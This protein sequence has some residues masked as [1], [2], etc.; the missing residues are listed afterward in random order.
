MPLVLDVSPT[1]VT[2]IIVSRNVRLL[3]Y[4]SEIKAALTIAADI[5]KKVQQKY[6]RKGLWLCSSDKGGIARI[7]HYDFAC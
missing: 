7:F 3:P 2:A 6:I 1:A 5:E 4:A